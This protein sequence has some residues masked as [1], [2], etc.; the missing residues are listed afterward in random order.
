MTIEKGYI[1]I[2]AIKLKDQ[3]TNNVN[4]IKYTDENNTTFDVKCLQYNTQNSWAK[5]FRIYM[6]C[7]NGVLGDMKV[8]SGGK[9]PNASATSFGVRKDIQNCSSN[10]NGKAYWGDSVKNYY[11]ITDYEAS[12]RV[13][14]SMKIYY[15]SSTPVTALEST[16]E[17]G[18]EVY[19]VDLDSLRTDLSNTAYWRNWPTFFRLKQLGGILGFN[20]NIDTTGDYNTLATYYNALRWDWREY[21]DLQIYETATGTI[22]ASNYIRVNREDLYDFDYFQLR[23][24]VTMHDSAISSNRINTFLYTKPIKY[25][26]ISTDSSNPTILPFTGRS[27]SSWTTITACD[28]TYLRAYLYRNPLIVLD[29]VYVAVEYTQG[30]IVGDFNIESYSQ[31]QAIFFHDEIEKKIK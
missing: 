11:S 23:I 17:L 14:E 31:Q 25:S 29:H 10:A 15:G 3:D 16:F 2:M 18:E 13:F 21:S 8:S 19:S 27:S 26:E 7:T 20:V 9:E 4:E 24:Y 28:T 5:P 1:F 22:P 6:N 30:Q 12:Q